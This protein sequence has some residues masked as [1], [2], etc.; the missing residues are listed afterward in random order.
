MYSS[1]IMTEIH[2]EYIARAEKRLA[3]EPEALF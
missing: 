3:D 2:E 1:W